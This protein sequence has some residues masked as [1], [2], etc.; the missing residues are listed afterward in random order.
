MTKKR[1]KKPIKKRRIDRLKFEILVSRHARTLDDLNT[2]REKNLLH[3]NEYIFTLK[4]VQL[5]AA[6]CYKGGWLNCR[7]QDNPKSNHSY[8]QG[9]EDARKFILEAYT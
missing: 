8:K 2:L 6:E 3:E 9:A 7:L 4:E 1:L 5:I